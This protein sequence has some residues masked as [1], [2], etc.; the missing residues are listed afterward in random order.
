VPQP[1]PHDR[2]QPGPVGHTPPP[3]G[4]PG[5][6]N[7]DPGRNL[8]DRGTQSSARNEHNPRWQI[9]H[10]VCDVVR[11]GWG[12][13][14]QAVAVHGS[15]AHADDADGSDVHIVVVT[16]F[17]GSGPPPT[18]RRVR[19]VVVDV[20]VIGADEYLRHAR[21]ITTSWPLV[22]DR[23][24]TTRPLHDP[25][26]W[27]AALR[28]CH[29]T[30]LA[31]AGGGEFAALARQAWCRAS[32]AHAKSRRLVDWYQTDAAMLLL[33]EARLSVALVDGLLTRTYFRNSADAVRRAGVA[34]ADITELGARLR[35]QADELARRGKPVD[36]DPA[37]LF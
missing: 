12:L 22:A 8:A 11:G 19:G 33:G 31:R 2:G 21:T 30:R 32:T 1:S 27:L 23:Y 26:R 16:R 5:P 6:R 9:A 35:D 10:E 36:A 17:P 24:L 18:T 20:G 14:L 7:G 3:R 4:D 34:A 29:L 25:D 28:D 37:D 15:L 13:E